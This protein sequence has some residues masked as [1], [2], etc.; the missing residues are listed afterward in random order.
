MFELTSRSP[1]LTGKARSSGIAANR[2]PCL[3]GWAAN[4]P[5]LSGAAARVGAVA[6]VL[7]VLCTPRRS[8]STCQVVVEGVH[9][10][11]AIGWHDAV[12]WK[13]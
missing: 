9:T 6:V 5:H 3:M 10:M 7:V 2:L 12:F 1:A 13:S 11:Y 8:P 4:T